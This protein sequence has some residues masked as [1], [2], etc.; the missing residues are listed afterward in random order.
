MKAATR[1]PRTIEERVAA[2]E[3][4]NAVVETYKNWEQSLTR[5][6]FLALFIGFAAGMTLA[7]WGAENA[8]LLAMVA[9][10]GIHPFHAVP[11]LSAQ[12]V[13]EENG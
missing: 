9:G 5:R 1:W 3:E 4:R 12:S 8:W 2:I 10:A 6:G 11:A 7:C 13:D